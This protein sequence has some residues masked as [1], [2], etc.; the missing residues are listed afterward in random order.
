MIENTNQIAETM[1]IDI[2]EWAEKEFN[3]GHRRHLG[4]SVIGD[5]C[6][7]R[8]WY[9]FR[10]FNN[11]DYSSAKR[12]S[13]QV[14]RLFQRGHREE[15]WF[16]RMLEAVGCKFDFTQDQQERI[17]DC[18]D[19][20]GGSL[21]NVGTLPEKFG[22]EEKVLFEFK[23][24]NTS[25]FRKLEKQGVSQYQ[26]K[27]W[28]QI[29]TYGFKRNLNYCFYASVNKDND[30]LFFRLLQLDHNLGKSMIDKAD[31]IINADSA[32]QKFAQTPTNFTCKMCNLSN[33]CHH[34]EQPKRNC[35]NCK[36]AS[37]EA[38]GEW[39]CNHFGNII[40]KDFI[41]L[42]CDSHEVIK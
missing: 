10:W 6:S 34:G 5:N 25:G 38:N 35:R 18:D 15:E 8:I 11:N 21:D 16:I 36:Y 26:P 42:G 41:P 1:L 13:G 39:Q 2:D 30:E 12:S 32:P 40:P 7:R 19:H 9:N 14:L 33:I 31:Y 4:A 3:D 28:A 37:P 29:C 22:I 23:T 24:I 27:H 17:S 20:F